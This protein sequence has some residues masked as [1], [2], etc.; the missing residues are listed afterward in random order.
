MTVMTAMCCCLPP[1]LCENCGACPEEAT[2]HIDVQM[3]VR[4]GQA[5]CDCDVTID[6]TLTMSRDIANAPL[7][8]GHEVGTKPNA[9][10]THSCSDQVPGQQFVLVVHVRCLASPWPDFPCLGG[11]HQHGYRVQLR[12]DISATP[13]AYF[14]HDDP[15]SS[16]AQGTYTNAVCPP[17]SGSLQG[18]GGHMHCSHLTTGTVFVT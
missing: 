15:D 10:A 2:V 9:N 16:C 7:D 4:F 13:Q 1:T 18:P 6:D 14:F 11:F 5:T 17:E 3:V 8:C 12:Y